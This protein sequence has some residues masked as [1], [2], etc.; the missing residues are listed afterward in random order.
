MESYQT[1]FLGIPLPD[2]YKEEFDK[3]LTDLKFLDQ[4]LTPV[5]T[6]NLDPHITIY[7]LGEQPAKNLDPIIQIATNYK[8]ILKNTLIKAGGLGYFNEK[9]PFVTFLKIEA[10]KQLNNYYHLVAAE[11]STFAVSNHADEFNPHLTLARMNSKKAKN[12]FRE[13]Q[14]ELEQLLSSIKFEFEIK[15]LIL[16]GKNKENKSRSH[17][18]LGKIKI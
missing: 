15:E 9:D 12:S 1:C 6:N 5:N 10:P 7:Y 3:L 16:Y 2:N 14:S 4:N 17:Q 18:R 8:D 13:K 11:L